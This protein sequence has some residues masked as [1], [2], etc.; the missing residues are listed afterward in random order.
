MVGSM[1]FGF[2]LLSNASEYLRCMKKRKHLK[3]INITCVQAL[4]S[5]EHD[6]ESQGVSNACVADQK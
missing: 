6:S 5:S 4:S 1:L 3:V 2:G